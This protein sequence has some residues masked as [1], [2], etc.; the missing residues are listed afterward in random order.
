MY[1]MMACVPGLGEAVMGILGSP[2]SLSADASH[3][4]TL[5]ATEQR[6][7]KQRNNDGSFAHE[8]SF[9]VDLMRELR[10]DHG[11][12]LRMSFVN[13]AS[14][15]GCADVVGGVDE[16]FEG[17]TLSPDEIAMLVAAMAPPA[18]P[19]FV[20]ESCVRRGDVAGFH[21]HVFVGLHEYLSGDVKDL[22]NY[23]GGVMRACVVFKFGHY[24]LWV[25]DPVRGKWMEQDSCKYK[26]NCEIVGGSFSEMLLG[27][28][29]ELATLLVPSEVY[30]SAAFSA[31][32]RGA[33]RV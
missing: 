12:S 6:P 5:M 27:S 11:I 8:D 4:L 25:R 10:V 31:A 26:R 15:H 30:D 2:G 3:T 16:M 23:L 28:G 1:G 32:W 18:A 22:V 33:A 9:L 29:G 17:C 24:V 13:A 21:S 19:L 7:Q 20:E 14:L